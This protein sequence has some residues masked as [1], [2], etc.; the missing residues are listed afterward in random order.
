MDLRP[1]TILT[2]LSKLLEKLSIGQLMPHKNDL[3]VL[4]VYYL[5]CTRGHLTTAALL[6]VTDDVSRSLD[7]GEVTLL[8]LLDYSRAYELVNHQLLQTS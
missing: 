3:Q 6:I 2:Y 4:P 7:C 8:A 1:V 5:G